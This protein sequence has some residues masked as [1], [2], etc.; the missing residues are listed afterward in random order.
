MWCRIKKWLTLVEYDE[1]GEYV[2]ARRFHHRCV[3]N[4]AGKPKALFTC[5][6]LLLVA[7]ISLQELRLLFEK[8][9]ITVKLC[10]LSSPSSFAL[11]ARI[12]DLKPFLV[13]SLRI[14]SHLLA[15]SFLSL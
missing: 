14:I 1:N 13:L 7:L 9:N 6:I 3:S 15:L 4:Q 10:K 8:V 11:V 5:W 12:D 2:E